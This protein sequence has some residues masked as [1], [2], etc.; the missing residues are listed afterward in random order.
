MVNGGRCATTKEWYGALFVGSGFSGLARDNQVPWHCLRTAHREEII[1]DLYKTKHPVTGIVAHDGIIRDGVSEGQFSRVYS[2]KWML[3]I[4]YSIW[5]SF[6][7]CASIQEGY[8]P[9]VTFVVVQKR[10]NTRLFPTDHNDRS[11]T[12]KSGNVLPGTVVD[13]KICHPTEFDF[14]L[15]SH[16]G[17]QGT[18]KPA[19]YHVLYDENWFSADRLQKL[20]NDLCYTYARCTRSVSIGHDNMLKI[21]CRT[22]ALP[23]EAKNQRTRMPRLVLACEFWMWMV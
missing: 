20:T 18:S 19:H 3:F 1:Q 7:A 9:P 13:T 11:K 4:R 5:L 14:Y 10:H 12:D 8:L 2:M 17:I 15:N 16:A 23:V 22:V 21:R 6:V